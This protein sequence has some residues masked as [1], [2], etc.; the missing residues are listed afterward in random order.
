[1]RR[2]QI[3]FG[4]LNL[5]KI[6]IRLAVIPCRGSSFALPTGFQAARRVPSVIAA[7]SE[8][9]LE[10]LGRLPSNETHLRVSRVASCRYGL[11][12]DEI[13]VKGWSFELLV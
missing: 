1:M 10:S 3:C 7:V 8:G 13:A 4:L 9:C 12:L 11:I 2:A 6:A 5:C